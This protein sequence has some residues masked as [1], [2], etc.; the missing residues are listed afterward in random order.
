MSFRHKIIAA[1][2]MC[3]LIIFL[4]LGFCL[5]AWHPGWVIFFLIPVMPVLLGIKKIRRIYPTL[6][7][8]IYLILGFGFSLWHPGWIIF[9][10]I[11]VVDIF[12][13]KGKDENEDEE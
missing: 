8:V 5:G 11:P 13:S 7:A 3:C 2:P 9:L 12:I 10:T 4:L 1:T 6:C